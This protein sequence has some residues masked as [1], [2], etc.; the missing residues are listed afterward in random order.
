M[1]IKCGLTKDISEF[2]KNAR[3]KDGY[4]SYCKSCNALKAKEFNNTPKGKINT[5]N[6]QKKQSDSG[7]FKYGKGAIQNMSRSASNRGIEFHLTEEELKKWWDITND[8]CFYCG[9]DIEKYR[10]IRDFIISYEGK[11]WEILRFKRFFALENQAKINDMTIDR[12]NNSLGY[13]V[14]NIVKSCW[15]CNSL[16]SD[17]FTKEEMKI[18]SKLVINNFL[19]YMEES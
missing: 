19:K 10:S 12:T 1:C 5:R 17:F 4:H 6:A 11:E 16:K 18:V 2:H 14:N 15:I 13:E 9:I 3:N 7:Y 8:I